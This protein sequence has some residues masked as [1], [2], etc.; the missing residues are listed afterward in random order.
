MGMHMEIITGVERRRRCRVSDKLRIL[1][2]LDEPGVRFN[3]V[4]RRH[5]T[6]ASALVVGT[7]TCSAAV[8]ACW[9]LTS[10]S[11]GPTGMQA[12]TMARSYGGGCVH[13]ASGAVCGC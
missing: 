10:P 2:E 6:L 4:A 9:S 7:V 11:S 5:T 3:G 13:L 1:V 12:A 8:G